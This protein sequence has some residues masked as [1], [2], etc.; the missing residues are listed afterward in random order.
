[1]PSTIP[2]LPD[3]APVPR[4][5]LGP[6]V[7]DKGYYVGPVERN[8]YWITDGDYNSAFLTTQDGVVL[9]DAPPTIGHKHPARRR[10]GRRGRGCEQQGDASRL[11]AP[12]L[13]PCRRIVSVRHQRGPNRPR[14]VPAL[15]SGQYVYHR[16]FRA[17]PPAAAGVNVRNQLLDACAQLTGVLLSPAVAPKLCLN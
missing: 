3:Y 14:G 11:H 9:F 2:A 6:A 8:L 7:N 12:P 4:S 1:M 17:A 10:R 15:V 16:M 5:S 13:R